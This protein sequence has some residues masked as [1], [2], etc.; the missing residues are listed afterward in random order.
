ME[1]MSTAIVVVVALMVLGVGIVINQL[2]RLRTWLKSSP[3]GAAP[4]DEA[5]EPPEETG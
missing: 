4:S 2:L 3:P 1:L 5:H